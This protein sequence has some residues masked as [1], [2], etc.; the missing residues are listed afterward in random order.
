MLERIVY[1]SRAA[2]GTGLDT[3][4]GIIRAAHLRNS[5][6]GI[7]GGLI[8]LDGW[9]VQV[10]EGSPE[11]VTRLHARLLRDPRHAG[12]DLRARERA[13]CRLFRGQAMALR[14]RACLDLALLDA[15]GYTPGFPVARFPADV[16]L[17][18]VVRACRPVRGPARSA[19]P[20]ADPA[21]RTGSD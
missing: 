10:L 3:V 13:L 1:V 17:E 19:R 4:F 16:L 2:P 6:A 9:F 11:A 21:N 20:R 14:T 18:F 8:F 7:S 15:F 5:Q 12:L